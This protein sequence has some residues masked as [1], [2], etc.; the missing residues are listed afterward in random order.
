MNP[1]SFTGLSVTEDLENF[2]EENKNVFEIIHVVDDERV[3]L[4]AYQMKGVYRIWFDQWKKNRVEGAPPASWA[5]FEEAF[6][7]NFFPRELREEKVREFLTLKKD[8]LSVHEYSLRFTKL[9]RYAPEI[10]A[11]IRSRMSLFVAELSC[12]SSKE[13]KAAMLIE[14]GK[15]NSSDSPGEGPARRAPSAPEMLGQRAKNEPQ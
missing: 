15:K 12:L 9:S 4:V 14:I 1:P 5:L 13:D 3:E 7:G 2:V 6:L 8:S 10:V 11:D